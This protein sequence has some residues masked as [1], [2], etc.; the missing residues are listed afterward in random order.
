[1]LRLHAR[2]NNTSRSS[3]RPGRPPAAWF[4]PPDTGST[5]LAEVRDD[6][7]A[8]PLETMRLITTRAA[9]RIVR[10][11]FVF[12]FGAAAIL[13][14]QRD[15]VAASA[16]GHP[17]RGDSSPVLVTV[18]GTPI[19]ENQAAFYRL[20][21][22]IPDDPQPETQRKVVAQLVEN[23]LMRQL[24]VD[25]RAEAD[26]KRLAAAVEILKGQLRRR[27]ADSDKTLRNL[28]YHDAALR[29]E[30]FLPLAWDY[31]LGR[32]I[33]QGAIRDE[34]ERHR[35]EYD[36][37]EVRASQIFIKIAGSDPA[38]KAQEA[39][40]KL[41]RLRSEITSGKISFPDAA[42]RYS[43]APSAAK[44]GDVGYFP[45]RGPMPA[46]V[47]RVAF[48]LKTGEVSQPF[49]TPFGVHLYTVT[50]IR[51]GNL[52]LEDVRSLVIR[53]L[54]TSL[55]DQLVAQARAKAKIEWPAGSPE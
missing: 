52:S 40:Q 11:L 2:M 31:H 9:H 46:E 28:G 53:R 51:P 8:R 41:G 33:T 3:D 34:F 35:T 29:R 45:F 44:G 43:E 14:G 4:I 20:I 26:P 23:E 22:R 1:M 7:A 21:H 38:N 25:R 39:E 19:T 50:E 47:C 12:I 24:L 16:T 5:E 42:R 10:S 54:S 27:S 49:R 13:V 32:V 48:S 6:P 15:S 55:W 17:R 36:G 18:N 37:T 30:L